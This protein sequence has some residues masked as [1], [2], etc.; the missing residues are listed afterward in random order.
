MYMRESWTD[1]RLDDFRADVDRRFDAVDAR[2][3][4]LETKVDANHRE[5]KA[6]I[7]ELRG[8]MTSGFER[9]YRTMLFLGAGAMTTIVV[10]FVGLIVT[11]A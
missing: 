4:R 11:H 8:E 2:F 6:E 3:D 1:E 9:L 10:G 5:V 7:A